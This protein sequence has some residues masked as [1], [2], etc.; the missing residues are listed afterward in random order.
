MSSHS[1]RVERL[2]RP[3]HYARITSRA[4]ATLA[5]M[6][7]GSEPLL[8]PDGRWLAMKGTVPAAGIADLPAA[9]LASVETLRVPGETAARHLVV[10]GGVRWARL[11]NAQTRR[12][13]AGRGVFGPGSGGVSVSDT[14]G[15]PSGARPRKADGS[16]LRLS[17]RRLPGRIPARRGPSA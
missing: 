4:F 12:M 7:A 1:D 17:R 14:I 11:R 2:D 9:L 3:G 16:V 5:D 10:I 15:C 13:R 6:V 8:A